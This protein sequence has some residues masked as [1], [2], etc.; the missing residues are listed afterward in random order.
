MYKTSTLKNGLTLI[1]KE[2]PHS[3]SATILCLTKA[4]SR[5]E[6]ESNK[7]ISHF[8]EHMFFK[9]GTIYKNAKEVAIAVDSF[10]GDFNAFTGKE[11]AW[12]YVK[13]GLDNIPTACD[14]LS[15]MLINATFQQSEIEKER[16]VIIEELNMYQDTPM[17]QVAWN[18]ERFL[19]WDQP[20]WWDTI[21]DKKLIL[22]VNS[23][24]FHEYKK[25]LYVPKN[26][27]I[28]ISGWISHEDAL[29]QVEKYFS[30][31]EWTQ[32]REFKTIV[33]HTPK[34][35][36][37]IKEKKTEQ[38]HFVIGGKWPEAKHDD[39]YIFKLLS[40]ICGG[41]MS[42]RMFL[43]VREARGLC[44]YVSTSTDD[45]SDVGIIST[46]AGVDINRTEEAINAIMEEYRK[47][48]EEKID[49]DELNKA[50]NYIKW[51]M[52][53]KLEDSEDIAHMLWKQ[54]LL[55]DEI[56]EFKEIAKKIDSIT[57]KDILRVAKKVFDPSN[58]Y[59][60]MIGPFKNKEQFEKLIK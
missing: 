32:T 53:L 11:Y 35:H 43:N 44:Y 10:G 55:Y 19:L 57:S 60:S 27:V 24:D 51:K 41:W 45:F 28:A 36:V 40:I 9:W 20:L 37:H 29:A 46:R 6:D 31:M 5:Y 42:S 4:G 56:L 59:L 54:C 30:T 2:I 26:S 58:L 16:N 22:N 3:E 14:V 34:Y 48:R 23:K 21:G 52:K 15:D 50:K 1:T 18:F 49:E 8:L 17:Y 25:S 38:C 47:L 13:C 39:S 33:E 12:Y 7:G